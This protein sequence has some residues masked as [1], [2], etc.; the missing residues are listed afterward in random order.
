MLPSPTFKLPPRSYRGRNS[1]SG[2]LGGTGVEPPRRPCHRP[3]GTTTGD[4]NENLRGVGLSG[5]V[6]SGRPN[7]RAAATGGT[8]AL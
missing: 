1:L 7:R 2:G 4:G 3:T 6:G 8:A 5:W